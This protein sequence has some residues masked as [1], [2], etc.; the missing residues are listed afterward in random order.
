MKVLLILFILI[1]GQIIAAVGFNYKWVYSKPREDRSKGTKY[2]ILHTTEGADNFIPEIGKNKSANYTISS[3]GEVFV[4]LPHDKRANHAGSSMW[5]GDTDL[6]YSSVGIEIVGHHNKS[7]SRNQINALKSLI[8]HIREIYPRIKDKHILTHS[9]VAYSHKYKVRGRK[10]CAMLLNH[11]NFRAQIGLSSGPSRDPDI[12]SH[13]LSIGNHELKKFLYLWNDP[14]HDVG[15]NID[16]SKRTNTITATKTPWQIAGE[17]HDSRYTQYNFRDGRKKA[18]NTIKNWTTIPTGTVIKF[19]HVTNSTTSNY[20]YKPVSYNEITDEDFTIK[21]GDTA[22]K[23]VG[24]YYN[25]RNTIY[26]IK[27]PTSYKYAYSVQSGAELFRN[28]P[29]LLDHLP[30]GTRIFMGYENGGIL[31][32]KIGSTAYNLVKGKWNHHTTIYIQDGKYIT[33]D[34]ID[35]KSAKKGTFIITKTFNL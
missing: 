24:K 29:Y 11:P 35:I 34:K 27:N 7:I 32:A 22:Y 31:N 9:M 16:Y 21:R 23:Y 28:D 30:V 12:E 14:V 10:K 25:S 20:Q 18:G 1:T 8:E 15:Y 5:D 33:G 13:R 2:I 6:N 19:L 17:L 26:I 3:N 4:T